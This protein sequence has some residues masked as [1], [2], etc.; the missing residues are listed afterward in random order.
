VKQFLVFLRL[1][2][3]CAT[4]QSQT[5]TATVVSGSAEDVVVRR[6]TAPVYPPLARQANITGNVELLITVRSDGTPQSVDVVSGHAMLKQAALDSA[7]RSEFEC[8]ACNGKSAQYRLIYVF[9]LVGEGDCC[10]AMSVQPTV[11][12]ETKKSTSTAPQTTGT[13]IRIEAPQAC[14]CDPAST[15]RS[16]VRSLKCLYLWRCS[17]R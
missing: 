7:T 1:I 4:L 6:L 9:S 3:S 15:V 10:Y 17:T 5:T 14:I 12:Q 8:V 11:T 13:R 2:A 16:R